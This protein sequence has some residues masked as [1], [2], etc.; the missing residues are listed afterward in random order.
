MRSPRTLVAL[1]ATTA[2]T[3]GVLALGVGIAGALPAECATSERPITA[4]EAGGFVGSPSASADGDLITFLA[5]GNLDGTN[6]NHTVEAWLYDRTSQS[7]MALTVTNPLDLVDAPTIS[8]DGSTIAYRASNDPLGTNDDGSTEIFLYDVATEVYAQVTSVP[9]GQDNRTPALDA[10]GSTIAIGSTGDLDPGG[11]NAGADEE[12]FL[13]TD[14]GTTWDQVT[15]GAPTEVS[16]LPALDDA[17]DDLVFLS[18]ADLAGPEPGTNTELFHQHLGDPIEQVTQTTDGVELPDISADGRYVSTSHDGDPVGTNVDANKEVFVYDLQEDDVQQI[19]QTT[20]FSNIG[21]ALDADG[22]RVAYLARTNPLG[23]NPDASD[24]VFLL[25]IP[26]D[27]LTQVTTSEFPGD[28]EVFVELDGPGTTVLYT[29][30]GDPVGT[31]DDDQRDLFL[32]SCGSS[33][34]TFTDVGATHPFL[35]EIEWMAAA[36]IS[37]GYLDVTYRPS[38]AVSRGAMSAFMY[39]LAGEPTFFPPPTP[40]FSDVGTGH[41]FYDEV[42]WMKATGVSTGYGDGTYRPA[43][44]VTRQS[45]SAFMYRLAGEPTFTAPGAATFTDVSLTHPFFDE[46]EWMASED[47]TT[48]YAPGP[49]YRPSTAVSRQAMSAFMLRLA[50]G[51]GVDVPTIL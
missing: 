19:T 41:P 23:A 16:L 13:S 51:P 42:Q 27:E 18:V 14:G 5:S 3:A 2:L 24:E 34:Q 37:T 9:A 8:A 33:G 32:A 10:D 46:I 39:R 12:V 30:K 35:D 21:A 48:G 26:A 43:D 36:R 7:V 4:L 40:S 29:S 17:G 15:N 22:S 1:G 50:N 20:A 44:P 25:D 38:L 31:N 49:T 11:D 6:A 45:M 47:I 28:P